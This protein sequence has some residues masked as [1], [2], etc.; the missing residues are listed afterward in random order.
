MGKFLIGANVLSVLLVLT[1][2][3]YEYFTPGYK[4][5]KCM[6]FDVLGYFFA[7]TVMIQISPI[8]LN[9]MKGGSYFG[10]TC[11]NYSRN[12]RPYWTANKK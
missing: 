4:D 8:L 7:L 12:T 6:S 11:V 10:L 5:F 3:N 1:G 2:S 9:L